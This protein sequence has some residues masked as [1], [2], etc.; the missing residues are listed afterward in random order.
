MKINEKGRKRGGGGGRRREII[1][2]DLKDC[3][4]CTSFIRNYESVIQI[5]VFLLRPSKKRRI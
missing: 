5:F 3:S 2:F 1:A 4:P